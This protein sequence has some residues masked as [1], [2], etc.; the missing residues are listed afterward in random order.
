MRRKDKEISDRAVILDILSRADV[1]RIAMMDGDVPYI[2]PVNYGYK[3]NALYIHGAAEGKKI[4]L[5]RRNNR[6]CFEIEDKSEIIKSQ[7]P[8]GWTARYRSLIGYGTMEIITGFDQKK[9]GLDII[10]SHVGN[11]HNI[12]V[13]SQ[14]DSVVILKLTIS[15]MTGKQSGDW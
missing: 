8:C 14:V 5:I 12:Y 2:V 7:T 15:T 10:M 3:D 9:Q 11:E 13:D 6:V 4:D 1:C